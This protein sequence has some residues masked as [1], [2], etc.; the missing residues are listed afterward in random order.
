MPE[1]NLIG[2]NV[3]MANICPGPTSFAAA[4]GSVAGP[5]VIDAAAGLVA[6]PLVIDAAAPLVAG[7]LGISFSLELDMVSVKEDGVE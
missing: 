4:A 7:P 1:N 6:G 2:L 5:L 3:N